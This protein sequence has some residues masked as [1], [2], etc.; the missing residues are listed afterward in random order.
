[1]NDVLWFTGTAELPSLLVSLNWHFPGWEQ[2]HG[3][4]PPYEESRREEG[5]LGGVPSELSPVLRHAGALLAAPLWH[6]AVRGSPQAVANDLVRCAPLADITVCAADDYWSEQMQR[7]G[8]PRLAVI[9]RSY[10][11]RAASST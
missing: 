10:D 11:Q 2:E 7:Y 3:L 4:P 5:N 8:V 1:M 6:R 9:C